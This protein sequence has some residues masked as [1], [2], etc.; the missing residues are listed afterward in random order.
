MAVSWSKH[1]LDNYMAPKLSELTECGAPDLPSP[2]NLMGSYILN[3][4]FVVEYRP[5]VQRLVFNFIRRVE[6]AYRE[7]SEGR[8]QLAAYVASDRGTMV[9]LYFGA[10]AHF[11]QCVAALCQAWAFGEK[12]PEQSRAFAPGDGSSAERIWTIHNDSKHM[13]ERTSLPP[14]YTTAVWLTNTGLESA[15]AVASFNELTDELRSC[16]EFAEFL[17]EELPRRLRE[18]HRKG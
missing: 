16:Y 7:Y 13:E 1:V 8:R 15:R 10:L 2:K 12:L 6:H 11:E 17:A 9:L 5:E 14:E 4:I 18:Q 3:R